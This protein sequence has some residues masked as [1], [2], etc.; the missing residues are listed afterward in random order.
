MARKKYTL[1]LDESNTSQAHNGT[2]F[3]CMAGAIVNDDDYSFIESQLDAIKRNVWNDLNNPE[4]YIL[5]QMNIADAGRGRL[6]FN[7]FPEYIRFKAKNI[8]E[9]FYES[10]AKIYDH[11]KICIVGG[12]VDENLL[13]KQF[14]LGKNPDKTYR[15]NIDKYLVTLQLLLENFCHFLCLHNGVG[16]IIYESR[17]I[18]SNEIVRDRFYHIKLMG[19]MYITKE[20]MRKHLLGIDF[21]EKKANNAGLQIADFIPNAFAREHAGFGQIDK[22]NK[23]IRKL[24]YYR[25]NGNCN[26]QDRFGIKNMP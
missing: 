24:K 19:S 5:H 4:R 10:L 25:Y 26:A 16:R 15:N 12:S 9:S 14:S 3:F 1:Y 17:E 2:P 22:N 7:K 23:Y 20:T 11:N 13:N 18:S 21:I 8:R 6:D